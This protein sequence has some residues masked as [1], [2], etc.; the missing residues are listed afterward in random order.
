MNSKR[1]LQLVFVL[2]VA[3]SCTKRAE[4]F[5]SKFELF[6]KYILNFSSGLVS[7]KSD[8]RVVLA[9]ENPNWKPNQ[10]LDNDLFSISPS[11]EGKV[12]ALSEN[13]VAFIP[14]KKLKQNEDYQ[15]TFHLSK[16]KETPKELQDFNFTVK[17]KKLDFT[18]NTE[19]LQSY[20]KDY[21]YLNG[22]IVCS[23]EVELEI[24]SK[25]IKAR[26]K[27]NDLK[28][29]VL[30]SSQSKTEFNFVIDSIQR[31]VE[32]TDVVIEW[33]GNSEDINQKGSME[34]QIP[35]KN[36][37][38]VVSA[39][40]KPEESQVLL[41]NFSDPLSREQDFSG[42]I[43]VQETDNLRFATAGNLL[44]VFFD[45]S[46]TGEKLIEV[47]RG[48]QSED[49]YKLKSDY[50]QKV[51]FEQTKPSI[52]F[53]KSGSIMPSSSNLKL[54]FEAVNLKAIDVKVYQI[55]NKNI[56]QFLQDNELNGD[57][58]LR[59]VASPIAKEKI[60]LKTNNILNYSKWNAY[61]IDLSKIIQ[62]DPGSI[63]RVELT[64]KKSYSL[65]KCPSSSEEENETEEEEN[66]EEI[67]SIDDY[68]S[69]YDYSYY[70]W[71]EREDPCSTSYYFETKIASNVIASDLGV[72][73]KRGN[74]GN[75]V[76]AVNDIVTTEPVED[77]KIEFFSFQQE[78]LGTATTDDEGIATVDLKKYAYFAIVSKDENKTY[79]KLDEG[80][81]LSISNFDVSGEE[82]QKG[83]KG[84]IYGERGVWRP[85]DPMFL[86][87]MLN[88]AESKLEKNHPIKL[89]ITD[90]QGK[91]RYQMVQKYNEM[92]HYRFV[93]QT[94][95]S[96]PTGNWEAK[97]SVGGV[98]FY[99][100]LKIETIK[101]N[102]LKIKNG[103]TNTTLFAN[104]LNRADIN[105]AWLHGAIAKNLRV[106]M[107]AKYMQQVTT[108]NGLANYDFDDDVRNFSTEEVNVFSGKLDEFGNA[109]VGI[110]PRIS[111]Q[112]P[113]KL[114]V[115]LQTKAYEPGGDFSTDVTTATLST[116]T[117]YVGIKAPVPNKYGMLETDKVNKYEIVSVDANGNPKSVSNLEVRVYKIEWRWWWNASD[118]DLSSYNSSEVTMPYRRYIVNTNSNGRANLAFSI[119][120]ADWG[121][122][123]IRVID[124]NGG[125]ATSIT[126]IIDWPV[127][128]GRTKSGDA[129]AANML[130]FATDKEKYNVGEKAIV[131]FPSSEGGRALLSLEN[132]SKVV[133]TIW[134]ETKKGETKVEIPITSELAPNVFVHISLLKP[135]AS[136]KND[137]PIRM[138][139]VIPIEVVDKNTLLQ[140]EI[141]MA[142]TIRPE[143]KTA[144]KV[145]EKSGKEMT[146][147]IAVVDDGLLDLTRFKTPNAWEKFYAKQA[148]GVKTWDV[149]DDVIGAYGGKINQIF[150]IGGDQDL[151]GGK[152]KKAN[153][154][155][156]VVFHLGPFK[157]KK[158]ETKTHQ[159]LMPNY[160]GSVR[161]MV[162]AANAKENAYGSAEKTTL[163][164]K[165]LM[166]LASFPRKISPRER[167]KV[168]VT[169]FAME[170]NIKNVTVQLKSSNGVKIIGNSVQQL[171]FE[172]PDEK[173]VFFEL[174]V[175]DYTGI[176]NLEV[177]ATSGSERS[178]YKVEVDVI[179]PNPYTQDFIDVVIPANSSKTLTWNTFGVT[180]SN[181]S[182]LEVSSFPTVNFNGRLNY[183]IQYPHG[184]V[185]QTTSSVFPQ[186]YL[187]EIVDLDSSRKTQI[188]NNINAAIN[189]LSNFQLPNGSLSYWQG[190]NSADDWGTSY[191]GHFMVEAEKK[192]YVL[193]MAFKQ[194]WIAYQLNVSKRWRFESTTHNDFAQAY[195]LYVLAL[196][197]NADM[198]SMNRLRETQGI[199]N[200]SKLR[201]AAAYA[202]VGQKNMATNILKV[203]STALDR[204]LS[205]YYYGSE[206]RNRAMLLETYVLLG[207]NKEAYTYAIKVAKDLS[208]N[209]YMSTQSTAYS[210][211][212]MSK[213]AVH[214]KGKGM[215]IGYNFGGKQNVISSTK[216][217]ADRKLEV[218]SGRNN[219][220]I[221]NKGNGALYIRITNAG[222][223]PVGQEK[224]VQKNLS[225]TVTYKSK[226][227]ATVSLAQV[228]Q[229]TEMV[230]EISITNKG[231]ESVSN[232]AL[233][234]IVPS[235]FEIMNSRHT[236]F[237]N[238]GNNV[239][240]YID[241]RD[242]RTQFYFSLRAGETRTFKVVVNATYLGQYYLPGIQ[243]EAMYDNNYIVRTKGQ[244]LNIV[245]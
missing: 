54:N 145:S 144:I 62:A 61:A 133:K 214:N 190:N 86:S 24:I 142:S 125:H 49:G 14:E 172:N 102:R 57:N 225:A 51:T 243:C 171:A 10:E 183:L 198:A 43:Q 209:K 195:R 199:S 4:D 6:K 36:N 16:L 34:F 108:F 8:I 130:V 236:D 232:I 166:T 114:K 227:G 59:S 2:V 196:S 90:P 58:N 148:L 201:L 60:I 147:T 220:T 215:Q 210:L 218:K 139:G 52:R 69:D 83:M 115:V 237:G 28:I 238:Y 73:A 129:S 153:R 45:Q 203:T 7:A 107:Q 240:D 161:T 76:I 233:S 12:V 9:F 167:I 135:H 181:K 81:S 3:V 121:R 44:K 39:E 41:I 184:C 112:A 159:I 170:K 229:G 20:S 106:D 1:L 35:G 96:D 56:L 143:Q 23:D 222:I 207:R 146:Y 208:S 132:G 224:T 205:Y 174:A 5:N 241:I 168:P 186:L 97:V 95:S 30:K 138:Y 176:A 179:N 120:E 149:Y 123:L 221:Q 244:W 204:D 128:S 235:G 103:F 163:V 187:S 234:Q 119:P 226:N 155:K 104:K 164:K 87:F 65:Y 152:A 140:P 100:S 110:N 189:K 25:V 213:F 18:I 117:T 74:N 92:N 75:Y 77:A 78:R 239:A 217:F 223:L 66:E 194:K 193:P 94:K 180:G 211:I 182:R 101:P 197:G 50:S 191:A 48:I 40:V 89:K 245:K 156:P 82:L 67:R 216:A 93:V 136:T 157:L 113:G 118:S 19:D 64:F 33:D 150:S 185:E 126:S 13:T 32:D 134:A 22:N 242:D 200:E 37:F 175:G 228:K 63:Y 206:D 31:Y 202:L 160:I 17:T 127:W 105:V 79:I 173:V 85:G 178:N 68:Y 124:N 162:V 109:K 27:D 231:N 131:S 47:F 230:A 137:A 98:H 84:F 219:V 177:I 116:Y 192:G 88:D 21:Q 99:K 141:S 71:E 26:Q 122:Y 212:A 165:P 53:I 46:V 38:K 91:V 158:G 169:V 70:N 42:L 154:F 80:R 72:I 11:I 55:F 111:S 29:K 151:G 188:Q 15:V